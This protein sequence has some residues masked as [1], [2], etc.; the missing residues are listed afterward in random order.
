LRD[1]PYAIGKE[2]IAGAFHRSL[3]G[4]AEEVVLCEEHN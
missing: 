3:M 2:R 1:T 4:R